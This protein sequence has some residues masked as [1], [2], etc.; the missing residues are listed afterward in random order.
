M[1]CASMRCVDYKLVNGTGRLRR[2][3]A[4]CIHGGLLAPGAFWPPASYQCRPCFVGLKLRENCTSESEGTCIKERKPNY[5]Q[6]TQMQTLTVPYVAI[7][8]L[9]VACC[10]LYRNLTQSSTPSHGTK[11][12]VPDLR[13][14]STAHAR[15]QKWLHPNT[16]RLA[17]MPLWG[18]RRQGGLCLPERLDRR[19]GGGG[20]AGQ[21]TGSRQWPFR[22]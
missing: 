18:A 15:H 13:A 22:G 20:A 21:Q 5:P 9:C 10:M 6:R 17:T 11:L 2:S 12:T 19:T 14:S 8:L 4:D 7:R 3:L 1:A 16:F